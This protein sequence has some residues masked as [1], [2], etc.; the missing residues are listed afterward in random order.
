MRCWLWEEALP[1]AISDQKK[2][3]IGVLR[4]HLIQ[5]FGT[6]TVLDSFGAA[7][8]FNTAIQTDKSIK[9][10]RELYGEAIAAECLSPY[11]WGEIPESISKKVAAEGSQLLS[12]KIQDFHFI[13]NVEAPY[14]TDA[15]NPSDGFVVSF[16]DIRAI[17]RGGA[18]EIL[19]GINS[20]KLNHLSENDFSL[21]QLYASDEVV[22]YP[23]GELSSPYIEQLMQNFSLVFSRIGTKDV[24]THYTEVIQ[25]LVRGGN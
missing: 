6:A 19:K 10:Q 5:K 22:I 7:E 3:A 18:L 12:G 21:H 8:A 14:G 15:K 2:A 16:R 23:T 9:K 25:K 1:K 4:S 24:P 11:H 13:D 17:S 20:E